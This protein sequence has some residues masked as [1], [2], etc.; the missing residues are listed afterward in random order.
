MVS[1]ETGSTPA[2]GRK[3][4]RSAP[5]PA[6]APVREN[7]VGDNFV[8]L[9][10]GNKEGGIVHALQPAIVPEII[11]RYGMRWWNT[12]SS[13]V[14]ASVLRNAV[15]NNNLGNYGEVFDELYEALP[16]SL[17]RVLVRLRTSHGHAAKAHHAKMAIAIGRLFRKTSDPRTNFVKEQAFGVKDGEPILSDDHPVMKHLMGLKS[18]GAPVHSL[19]LLPGLLT[20][21]DSPWPLA[22]G[23][24]SVLFE[25]DRLEATALG[26]ST[27]E[28]Q[29][30]FME[31]LGAEAIHIA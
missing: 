29:K 3:R 24:G 27:D 10:K 1:Q 15:I 18:K 11:A 13:K 16:K 12:E 4:S 14:A 20:P 7:R 31:L 26:N 22:D 8:M 21:S 28:H 6:D 19:A 5:K 25:S 17:D 2:S 9:I 30:A 23:N